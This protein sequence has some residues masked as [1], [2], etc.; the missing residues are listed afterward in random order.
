MKK[1]DKNI[2]AKKNGSFIYSPCC[3]EEKI[4]Y[5]FSWD[6]LICNTCNSEIK[7]LNFLTL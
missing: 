7:K 1:I 2:R 5:H 4:V 6:A 3:K